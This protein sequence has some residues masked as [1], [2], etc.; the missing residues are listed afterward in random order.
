MIH[1]LKGKAVSSVK[2]YAPANLCSLWQLYLPLCKQSV[3]DLG[4]A[5]P[6]LCSPLKREKG[7]CCRYL[8]R[9]PA[10]RDS[11]WCIVQG[12]LRVKQ[13]TRSCSLVWIEIWIYNTDE[14]GRELWG[15]WTIPLGRAGL[16]WEPIQLLFTGCSYFTHEQTLCERRSVFPSPEAAAWTVIL[17]CTNSW[18]T[19]RLNSWSK[20]HSKLHRLRDFPQATVGWGWD[21]NWAILHSCPDPSALPYSWVNN[22]SCK[23]NCFCLLGHVCNLLLIFFG[24]IS[25][26]KVFTNH[27]EHLGFIFAK[28][29][30]SVS[31]TR[32]RRLTAWLPWL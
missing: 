20:A 12:I 9:H 28:G 3:K 6:L 10:V 24:V 15:L 1:A 11:N 22:I 23:Q 26:L 31:H 21:G 14:A 7:D 2:A 4:T 8:K 18:E 27:A 30:G 17:F 29:F 19:C 32:V 13:K 5:Q 25:Y 16:L